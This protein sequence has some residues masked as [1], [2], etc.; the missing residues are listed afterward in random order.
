VSRNEREHQRYA[1]EVAVTFRLDGKV[2]EGRTRNVS[3]GGLCASVADAIPMGTDIDIDIVLMFE[4]GM[5]SEALRLPCRVA[6]C[7]T[8]DDAHQIG[9]AFRGMDKKRAD[10]LAVFLRCL[11][12]QRSELVPRQLS[13]DDRFG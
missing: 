10:Y 4:D 9:V 12:D 8:L 6:W 7:T 1:H 11:D 13:L 2:V 5:Q 3:R